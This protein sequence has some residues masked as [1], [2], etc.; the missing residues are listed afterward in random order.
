MTTGRRDADPVARLGG[1]EFALILAGLDAERAERFVGR[2]R[3]RIDS[4]TCEPGDDIGTFGAGRGQS[5]VC[6]QGARS[7]RSR[8]QGMQNARPPRGPGI[9]RAQES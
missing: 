8:A 4:A 5:D 3:R 1:D 6:G 9:L 2:L 7:R